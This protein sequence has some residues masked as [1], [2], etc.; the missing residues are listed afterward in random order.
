[1]VR[2]TDCKTKLLL[3]HLLLDADSPCTRLFLDYHGLKI[4]NS[5]MSEL[6]WDSA[7][8]LDVKMAVE[9]ALGMLNIPHKTMLVD[10]GVWQTIS[11][12]STVQAAM[13]SEESCGQLIKKEEIQ[14]L[15]DSSLVDTNATSFISAEPQAIESKILASRQGFLDHSL[16]DSVVS[17]TINL[18]EQSLQNNHK[19]PMSAA[20]KV[21]QLKPAEGD[22]LNLSSEKTIKGEEIAN[23][24]SNQNLEEQKVGE[25]GHKLDETQPEVLPVPKAEQQQCSDSQE[26]PIPLIKHE[27]FMQTDLTEKTGDSLQ[28]E[29]YKLN[30]KI[31]MIK[32]KALSLLGAWKILKEVFKIPRKELVKLRAEHEREVDDAEA[33]ATSRTNEL[34]GEDSKLSGTYEKRVI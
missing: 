28:S 11:T 15:S 7:I 6:S 12:W 26:I 30:T 33:H 23:I 1:M 27:G 2:A 20:S 19:E 18:T 29:K 4:L 16:E 21:S 22:N 3:S 17:S 10:S 5:W 9:D 25:N 31:L 32:E 13:K 14:A 34:P 8:D 24:L